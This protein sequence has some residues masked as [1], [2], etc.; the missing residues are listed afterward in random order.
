M[1]EKKFNLIHTLNWWEWNK[2]NSVCK[3]PCKQQHKQ[4][5]VIWNEITINQSQNSFANLLLKIDKSNELQWTTSKTVVI[6]EQNVHENMISQMNHN[7][8]NVYVKTVVFLRN[9]LKIWQLK[10]ITINQH[11]NS[12]DLWESVVITEHYKDKYCHLSFPFSV[13]C[14]LLS[15]CVSCFIFSDIA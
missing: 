12:G 7:E 13:N 2:K 3:H 15:L 4:T 5:Y 8:H 1:H 11:Q 9:V 14:Y 10:W 6:Y